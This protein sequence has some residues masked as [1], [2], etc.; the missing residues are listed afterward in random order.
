ME[1]IRK[2]FAFCKSYLLVNRKALLL[3]LMWMGFIVFF[4]YTSLL[5]EL[6]KANGD[7]LNLFYNEQSKYIALF[8]NVGIVIML[9]FDNWG[10][11]HRHNSYAFYISIFAIVLCLIIM[12]HCDLNI[13]NRLQNYKKPISCECLSVIIHGLFLLLVYILKVNTLTKEIIK[14]KKGVAWKQ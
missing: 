13:S 4:S 9:L 3:G 8:V 5:V 1:M 7:F 12:A 11:E 2:M 6:T 10:A 14:T